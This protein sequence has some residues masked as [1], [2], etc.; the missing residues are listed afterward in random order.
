M[1]HTPES[2]SNICISWNKGA[3]IF[4]GQCTYRHTCATC[5]RNHRAKDCQQT[6]NSSVYK[7]RTGTPQHHPPIASHQKGTTLSSVLTTDAVCLFLLPILLV[8]LSFIYYSLHT[9]LWSCHQAQAHHCIVL[10]LYRCRSNVGTNTIVYQQQ[11]HVKPLRFFWLVCCLLISTCNNEIALRIH[12]R[13][14]VA[15][16]NHWD[17]QQKNIMVIAA[18]LQPIYN[19]ATVWKII[20][21]RA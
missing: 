20:A 10:L 5:H 12:P 1:Q 14:V 4:P 9:L 2:T 21:L 19:M 8:Y 3:C 16:W 17:R 18:Q 13:R 6:P 7:L 11:L 15:S